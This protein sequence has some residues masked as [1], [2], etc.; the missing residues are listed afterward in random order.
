MDRETHARMR[1]FA[2]YL[3]QPRHEALCAGL[4]REVRLRLR[5]AELKEL[6]R[7]GVRTFAEA[8]E[9]EQDRRRGASSLTE[10]P[11]QVGFS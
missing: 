7:A 10:R 3:A 4:V 11:S 6:R 2:R 9:Y 1:V 8:E 5:I